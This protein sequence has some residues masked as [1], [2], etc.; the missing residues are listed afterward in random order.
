MHDLD[1]GYVSVGEAARLLCLSNQRVGQLCHAGKL[2]H[3]WTRYGREVER[4][5]LERVLARRM[6]KA[7]DVTALTPRP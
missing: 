7:A 2:A 5:D 4:A 6:R 3:R 1:T